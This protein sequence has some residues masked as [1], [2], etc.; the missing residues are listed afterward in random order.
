[1]PSEDTSRSLEILEKIIDQVPPNEAR[2]LNHLSALRGPLV[3]VGDILEENR[4]RI[5]SDA[6]GSD[7][8]IIVRSAELL[9]RKIEKGDEVRLDATGKVAVEHF[10]HQESRDYFFEEVPE[11]P[12]EAVGGQ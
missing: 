2:L 10:E 12:W 6:P 9:E 5:G 4:L 8:R 11:I 3:K 7:G 1:M